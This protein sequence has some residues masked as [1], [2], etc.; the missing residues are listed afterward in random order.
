METEELRRAWVDL[1]TLQR[2]VRG[3]FAALRLFDIMKVNAACAD[4]LEFFRHI[5]E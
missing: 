2:G 5:L 1:V 4:W 3:C